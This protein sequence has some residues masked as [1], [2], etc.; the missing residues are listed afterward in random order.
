MSASCSYFSLCVRSMLAAALLCLAAP[1]GFAGE[2]AVDPGDNGTDILED[3]TDD[4]DS[5]SSEVA[6]A[7]EQLVDP[8]PV[9]EELPAI[10]LAEAVTA[11]AGTAPQHSSPIPKPI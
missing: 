2:V 10:P 5:R 11:A 6:V 9:E 7:V 1:V 4:A 3:T 8:A